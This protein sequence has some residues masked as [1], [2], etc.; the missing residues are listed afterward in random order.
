[1]VLG[2]EILEAPRSEPVAECDELRVSVVSAE[3]GAFDDFEPG[4]STEEVDAIEDH[5]GFGIE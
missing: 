5:D 3:R 1:V 2:H 4:E